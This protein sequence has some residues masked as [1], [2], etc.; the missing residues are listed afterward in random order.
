LLHVPGLAVLPNAAFLVGDML[1]G[2][3]LRNAGLTFDAK[4]N[5][6]RKDGKPAA[7]GPAMKTAGA[8]AA[9][10]PKP[11]VPV[12]P[13]SRGGAAGP[14]APGTASGAK[15][16]FERVAAEGTEEALMAAFMES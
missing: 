16:G 15:R 1:A 9:T 6:V 13:P 2:E 11:K 3:R 8:S 14:G 12:A 7:A 10:P 5:V 4:G